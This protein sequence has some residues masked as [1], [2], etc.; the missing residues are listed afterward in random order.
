MP[1]P[2]T[3]SPVTSLPLPP[4]YIHSSS[5]HFRDTNGRTLLLRGINLSGSAKQPVGMKGHQLEG[6]WE[7]GEEGEGGFVGRPLMLEDGSGDVSKRPL[8]DGD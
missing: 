6:F 7:G 4:H 8:S 3:T 1:P 2:P 5:L